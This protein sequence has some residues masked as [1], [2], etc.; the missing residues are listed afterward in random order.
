MGEAYHEHLVKRKNTAEGMMLRIFVVLACVSSVIVGMG[1][2]PLVFAISVALAYLVRYVFHAT[3]VEYE[4]IYISG[5]I[6]ISKICGKMKRKTLKTF[7]IENLEMLAPEGDDELQTFERQ[8]HQVFDYSSLV[9]EN[10]KYVAFIRKDSNLTKIIFE[11]S[12]AI[13]KEAKMMAPRKVVFKESKKV[14]LNK[15]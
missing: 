1:T 9:K 15:D 8:E 5:E 12:E 6:E 10:Q 2:N 7:D 13:V 3:D 4:Y 11:P 14:E